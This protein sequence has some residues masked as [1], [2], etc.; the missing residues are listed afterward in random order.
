ME[1]G[2]TYIYK[3]INLY[4]YTFNLHLNLKEKNLKIFTQDIITK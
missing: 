3:C 1:I 4:I 2:N